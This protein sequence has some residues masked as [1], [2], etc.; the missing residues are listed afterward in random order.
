MTTYSA[1]ALSNTIRVGWTVEHVVT[2]AVPTARSRL[3]AVKSMAKSKELRMNQPTIRASIPAT[4]LVLTFGGAGC[5][6]THPTARDGSGPRAWDSAGVTIV[7]NPQP[8]PDA[9]LP[10]VFGAQPSLSIGAVDSGEDDQLFRVTDATRL[11]DGRI[12]I[13]NSGSNELR[14]FTADGSHAGNWGGRGEGPGEFTSY[15]PAAVALWPGDSVAAANPWGSRLSLFDRDGNHGRDVRLDTSLRNILDL[16]PDGKIVTRGSAGIGGEMTGT[17]GLV[18][19]EAEWG[20]LAADGTMHMSL[21][22]YPGSEAWAIFGSDGSI[23]SVRFH[24]FG[25]ATL[26]AVW[27]DLVAIGVQDNYEIKAFATDG[28]L[29][30]IVR[31]DGDLERPTRAD[32]NAY[33]EQR[34]ANRPDEERVEALNEVK[35][36]PL[37]DSYPAFSG[38]L[39]DRAGY[40]WV[41][42][43]QGAAWT[44][45]DAE[46]Q[47]H[48]LVETPPGLR[49][50]EIGE[51]YI[52]GWKYDELGV[53]YVQLWSLDRGAG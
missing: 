38:V 44:V 45:F 8:A 21:G 48:G 25:R 4:V 49:T 15:S 28:S 50:F 29:V 34:Y 9:R 22:E 13:A 27:G 16:L 33:W 30:R 11:P 17:S 2:N 36:M 26:G 43:Y 20:I 35:D 19:Q 53:E 14:V 12:V 40:L 24:P 46:G 6:D 5:G 47:I 51:D 7:E 3:L 37:V 23:R 42:E 41:R 52:L 32:Q 31:R 10:W 18:R 39:A 1:I